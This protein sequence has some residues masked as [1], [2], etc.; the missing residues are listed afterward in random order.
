MNEID[1]IFS[2]KH[3]SKDT[4]LAAAAVEPVVE[5][6]KNKKK[7]KASSS[8]AEITDAKA[9]KSDK[10]ASIPQK[11]DKDA[12]VLPEKAEKALKKQKLQQPSGVSAQVVEFTETKLKRPEMP[13]DDFFDRKRKRTDDGLPI[14]TEEELKIGEGGDTENCPFDCWCCY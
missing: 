7:K 13:K 3:T 1:E 2:K 9:Q 10:D 11:T 8:N 12:S 6:K 5:T 4:T 14:Y